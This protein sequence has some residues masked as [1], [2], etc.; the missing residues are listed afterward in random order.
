[1]TA[2]ELDHLIRQNLFAILNAR[3]DSV[4]YAIEPESPLVGE[5]AILDSMEL[6]NLILALEAGLAA[7]VHREIQ[8]LTPEVFT[9]AESPF[10]SVQRLLEHLGL[11]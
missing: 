11:R 5:G 10:Q 2:T 6:V 3:G 9:G 1:M 4:E 8:L 7:N